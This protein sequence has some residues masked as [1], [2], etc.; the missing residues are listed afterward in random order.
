MFETLTRLAQSLQ[1][2]WMI[3]V[4]I[5]ISG[6]WVKRL[7]QSDVVLFNRTFKI[8]T[9]W[10]TM[11]VGS[12]FCAV[13]LYLHKYKT[14]EPIDVSSAFKTYAITTSLYELLIKVF[15]KWIKEETL[16]TDK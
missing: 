13:Y 11:I 1:L 15:V 5:L 10:K 8:S 9:A 16:T 12:V 7:W 14:G 6:F 4:L 3:M 2:D